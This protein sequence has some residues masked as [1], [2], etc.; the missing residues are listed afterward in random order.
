MKSLRNSIPVILLFALELVIGILLLVSPMEFTTAVFIAFGVVLIAIGV[1]YLIRYFVN[2]KNGEEYSASML[3]L[4]VVSLL[5][6]CAGAFCSGLIIK[7]LSMVWVIYGIILLISGIYKARNYVEIRKN[8]QP[9]SFISLISIIVSMALG[10]VLIL[11][12]FA[13]TQTMWRFAGIVLIIEGF[14]DYSLIMLAVRVS[15]SPSKKMIEIN[16]EPKQ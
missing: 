5:V 16:E 3:I 13:A 10:V 9:G 1:I 12:P 2:R 11:N 15:R 4:S 6:G 7:M 8:K 14:I